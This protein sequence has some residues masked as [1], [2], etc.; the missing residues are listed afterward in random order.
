MSVPN[1]DGDAKG[2]GPSRV[3]GNSTVLQSGG[4]GIG[5]DVN[6]IEVNVQMT[7]YG[8]SVMIRDYGG[9]TPVGWGR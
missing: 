2:A 1:G 9:V 4:G 5:I 7:K 6:G 3:A 8:T